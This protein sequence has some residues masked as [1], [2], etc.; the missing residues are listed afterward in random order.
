MYYK[1]RKFQKKFN[2]NKIY[3]F[4]PPLIVNCIFSIIF[5]ISSLVSILQRWE[6][7]VPSLF[8][9]ILYVLAAI[10][11]FTSI[12]SI[13]LLFKTSPPLQL[14]SRVANR[15]ILFSKLLDSLI[16]V[17]IVFLSSFKSVIII[18][19]FIIPIFNYQFL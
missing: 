19:Y 5:S 10:F 3:Q 4:R 13:V 2:W 18:Y 8:I 15:N 14:V 1:R 7:T 11:L 9:Y 16:L 6:R 12:W 17:S